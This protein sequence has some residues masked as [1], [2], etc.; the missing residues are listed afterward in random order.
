[1]N[2]AQKKYLNHIR[3]N[4]AYLTYRSIIDIIAVLGYCLAGITALGTLIAGF[5]SM[6][7]SVIGGSITLIGGL[8]GAAL[9]FLLVA[10]WKEASLILA[11]IGDSVTDANSKN[12]NG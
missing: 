12:I 2:E 6:Q 1:M 7:H 5:R 8:L 3:S 10:F 4:T 9:I 11:D